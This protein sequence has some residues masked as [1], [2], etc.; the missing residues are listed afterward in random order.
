VGGMRHWGRWLLG[1]VGLLIATPFAA[2]PEIMGDVGP[3]NVP[4]WRNFL[5][6]GLLGLAMVGI[7]VSLVA[8]ARSRWQGTRAASE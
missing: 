4:L 8:M 1:S 6:A 7:A 5:G 3:R 2:F